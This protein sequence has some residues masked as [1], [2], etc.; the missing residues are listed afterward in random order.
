MIVAVHRLS[1]WCLADRRSDLAVWKPDV[2]RNLQ[3]L[4]DY[5]K[6]DFEDVFCLTFT[7][8]YEVWRRRRPLRAFS[9]ILHHRIHVCVFIPVRSRLAPYG[10]LS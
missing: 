8:S 1:F 2:A 9:W 5:E 3:A 4:L 10:S 7:L 6:P